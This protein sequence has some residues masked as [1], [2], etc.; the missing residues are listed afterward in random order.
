MRHSMRAL[1]RALAIMAA[2]LGIIGLAAGCGSSDGKPSTSGAKTID[3]N[4]S[5]NSVTPNGDK[6]TVS[7]GQEV[8]L[9]VTADK[10]GEIHVHTQP[11]KEYQYGVGTTSISLGTMDVPGQF[12]VESHAL[13]KTIVILQVQ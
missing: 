4:F 9:E 8:K 3:V 13:D 10:A 12:E 2:L 1:C 6:V 11:A 5:G 7:R